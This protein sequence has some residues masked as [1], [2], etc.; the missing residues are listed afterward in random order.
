[1]Q[2]SLDKMYCTEYCRWAT[3]LL[4]WLPLD[5]WFG[6]H[7]FRCLIC[8]S[9]IL[10]WSKWIWNR[11]VEYWLLCSLVCSHCSL[12]C[13]IVI[14]L[15]LRYCEI[16]MVYRCINCH[17]LPF[18]QKKQEN[19]R[20]EVREDADNNNDDDDDGDGEFGCERYGDG[21]RRR[22]ARERER[23]RQTDRQK[24]KN[25][26]QNWEWQKH[27][28]EADTRPIRESAVI[29]ARGVTC[30]YEKKY[31]WKADRYS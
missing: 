13:S 1:M 24:T 22:W 14:Y 10:Q 21:Q 25:S 30:D 26:E 6:M 17:L 28:I 19:R 31:C 11:R 20:G 5:E 4:V 15:M 8:H 27:E 16:H 7:Y 9:T 29:W 18:L 23:D 3:G 2:S 12:I